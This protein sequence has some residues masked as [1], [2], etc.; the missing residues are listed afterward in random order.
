MT[1]DKPVE[2]VSFEIFDLDENA[3]S[4]DDRMTIIATDANGDQVT[5][6]YSDLDGLHTATDNVIDA[7]G[8]ASGGVETFGADDSVTVN[9]AGPFVQ[10][11]MIFDHGEDSNDSGLYGISDLT[12]DFTTAVDSEPDDERWQWQRLDLRRQR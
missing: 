8:S 6:V 2:N 9:I 10:L 12:M 11:T 5:V 7:D 3:G 4:W 1:F